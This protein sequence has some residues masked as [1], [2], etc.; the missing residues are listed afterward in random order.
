MKCFVAISRHLNLHMPISIQVIGGENIA[1]M[2][3]KIGESK[4][5]IADSIFDACMK[6]GLDA[7]GRAKKDYLTGPHPEKLGV[8]TGRLRSS[9]TNRITQEGD[10]TTVA[11]GTKVKYAAI[12]ELGG[13]SVVPITPN[14]RK[15]FWAKFFETGD[16]K[17]KWMALTKKTRFDIRIPARPF[18]QPAVRDAMPAFESRL[19]KILGQLSFEGGQ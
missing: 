4:R 2:G 1:R 10:V 5:L 3:K 12:H 6:F 19:K 13:H 7:E 9:I 14:S 8:G 17:F 18:L 11:V 16:E 15:A